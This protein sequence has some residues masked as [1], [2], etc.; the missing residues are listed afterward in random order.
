MLWGDRVCTR[1]TVG[2]ASLCGVQWGNK[3]T[4]GISP[5][6]PHPRAALAPPGAAPEFQGSRDFA[7]SSR[8]AL[9]ESLWARGALPGDRCGPRARTGASPPG[10]TAYPSRGLEGGVGSWL[11]APVLSRLRFAR[12]RFDGAGQGGAR[13][14]LAPATLW[15]AVWEQRPRLRRVPDETSHFVFSQRASQNFGLAS[16]AALASPRLV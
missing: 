2:A 7:S 1:G 12:L 10:C 8:A 5:R 15:E 9:L 14:P 13:C 6:G 3:H 11:W 4:G 16:P